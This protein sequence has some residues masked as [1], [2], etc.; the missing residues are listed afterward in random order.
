[1]VNIRACVSGTQRPTPSSPVRFFFRTARG[2]VL[3]WWSTGRT[4][5]F[6][7][8]EYKVLI[9]WPP[10]PPV[11]I[12]NTPPLHIVTVQ[13]YTP[14]APLWHHTS[15][16]GQREDLIPIGKI[17]PKN[18]AGVLE[19]SCHVCGTR[20]CFSGAKITISDRRCGMGDE[21]INAL[22]CLKSWYRDGLISA[23]HEEIALLEGT[24]AALAR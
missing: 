22:E 19:Y 13:R 10:S 7:L 8:T 5:V 16:I 20:T 23:R 2:P 14:T 15:H 24:M 1:M 17:L 9:M 4:A 18:G 6:Y 21:A 11:V 3:V 12:T